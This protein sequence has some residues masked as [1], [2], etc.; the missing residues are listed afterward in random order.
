MDPKNQEQR[1]DSYIIINAT[2]TEAVTD[3][4]GF[5]RVGVCVTSGKRRNP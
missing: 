5:R 1:G 2:M 3:L 4:D